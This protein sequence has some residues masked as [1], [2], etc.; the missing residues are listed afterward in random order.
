MEASR[1][2]NF[3]PENTEALQ[4]NRLGRS[5]VFLRKANIQKVNHSSY[6]EMDI[7]SHSI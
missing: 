6:L 1:G 7:I 3:S 4:I 5:D 2:I